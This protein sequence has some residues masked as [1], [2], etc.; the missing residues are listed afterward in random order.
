MNTLRE[1]YNK[2][3]RAQIKEQ[4]GMKN[5]MAVPKV[6]KVVLNIGL[7]KATQ[8]KSWVEYGSSILQRISGQ[9]PV[10]TKAKKSIS[11]FKVREGNIVGAKV[12]L[13]GER[14]YDFLYKLINSTLPRLRDFYGLD[15]KKGFDGNG[16]YILGF[17]EHIVFPEI[18]MEDIEKIHGLEIAVSTSAK[19]DEQAAALLTALG[20]PFKKNKK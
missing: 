1:K 5:I 15:N 8:D 14:M 6:Q 3:L 20:F 11:N 10:L 18:G 17:K 9:K 16:N 7:G 13:R 12:T 2:E 4:L 19:N